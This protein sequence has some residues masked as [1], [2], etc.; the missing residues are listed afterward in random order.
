[1]PGKAMKKSH[2]TAKQD[3]ELAICR[4][5][6]AK[7][8]LAIVGVS[9]PRIEAAFAAV[10]RERFLG[11]G[12]WKLASFLLGYVQTPNADPVYLYSNTLFALMP[13]KRLNNGEPS[14]YGLWLAHALP[15]PGEH[16]VH[17]GAGVGYYTAIMA[18]LV[19]PSGRVTGIEY[20]PELA[21]RA[22]Q[23]FSGTPNVTILEGDGTVANFGAADVICV[24]AGA[25]H[26]VDLWLDRLADGGRLI[27]PLAPNNGIGSTFRIERRGDGYFAK[28]ISPI[29][30]YACAGGRDNASERALAE[31][32]KN[33][34]SKRVTRLYR[35]TPVPEEDCW[36]RGDQWCLAYR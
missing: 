10:R 28:W 17:I 29:A 34:Q 3:R 19:G 13:E 30:I 6:Y 12:P 8:I 2:A 1:M 32:L 31:A 24:S 22:R 23:N 26:P 7:Q 36:L 21:E 9:E 27:L 35:N 16:V 11:P 18:H 14:L 15:S 25:T 33:G 4:R 20:V 5:A